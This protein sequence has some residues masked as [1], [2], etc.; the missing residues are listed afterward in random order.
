[1]EKKY[2]VFL[3]STY[4]DLQSERQLVIT[5]IL[6]AGCIPVGMEL[7]PASHSDPLGYIKKVI[8]DCD[9]YIIIIAG[10]YGSEYDGISFTEREFNYALEQGKKIVAF[11]HR[12]PS[13]LTSD[14]RDVGEKEVKLNTLKDRLQKDRLVVQWDKSE[15]LPEMILHSLMHLQ[16]DHESDGWIKAS[17][18]NLRMLTQQGH[19]ALLS[20][21][22]KL[23]K[24][25]EKLKGKSARTP[26]PVV[27]KIQQKLSDIIKVEFDRIDKQAAEVLGEKV[28]S[29]R[30][31][32]EIPFS[33]EKITDSLSLLGVP[34]HIS[35]EVIERCIDELKVMRRKSQILTTAD[36]RKAVSEVLYRFE[37][38]GIPQKKIQLWADNYI[39][40]YGS[41][42]RQIIVIDD[43]N[44]LDEKFLPLAFPLIQKHV[45][46]D[47]A[48]QIF[49]DD[50]ELRVASIHR[51]DRDVFADEIMQHIKSLEIYRIHYSTAISLA[52][53]LALS[54]PHPWFVKD[55]NVESIVEY[56]LERARYHASRLRDM[57]YANDPQIGFH[58]LRECFHHS[59]SGILVMYRVL[60]G[61]GY[62]SP[63]YNL[64][65]HLNEY[66]KGNRTEAYDYSD[67]SD[68]INNLEAI[69]ININGLVD[70]LKKA[71]EQVSNVESTDWENISDLSKIAISL[72]VLFENLIR[73][74]HPHIL[75]VI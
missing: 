35:C 46:I 50:Y 36:I 31:N 29:I 59:C 26:R 53:D 56:D 61:C 58:S 37:P 57:L 54:P 67:F 10:R 55:E 62:L 15:Q 72:K 11:V 63:L 1:M 7:F 38:Q 2:Q 75:S 64:F 48:K 43:I 23:T 49:P 66:S 70:D 45:L 18:D 8:D 52:K 68:L 14:K 65:H 27:E 20:K 4:K 13:L 22:N 47:V 60:P 73:R 25:V 69:K 71:Q 3:S 32:Q 9:Y 34:L 30:T 19:G 17:A 41:P 21:I 33:A 5:E 28:V 24:Q 39:R 6:K 12:N 40:V 74:K 16:K 44:V 42:S 51:Q